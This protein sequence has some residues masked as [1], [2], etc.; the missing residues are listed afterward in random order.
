VRDVSV[1]TLADLDR[2]DPRPQRGRA[3][4]GERDYLCP[5]PA[6]AD[7]QRSRHRS[8]S[9]NVVS[10]RWTCH[11]CGAHGILSQFASEPATSRLSRTP[12]APLEQLHLLP[13]TS[14][15]P[16]YSYLAEQRGLAPE[17]AIAAGVNWCVRS[18]RPWLALP[19]RDRRGQ[20]VAHQLR[21]CDGERH[22]TVGPKGQGVF[23][24]APLG[25]VLA[26]IA[27]PVVE[28][29]LDALSVASAG[30]HA[31]ATCG[32]SCADWL[33]GVLVGHLVLLG[34]DRD[35]PDHDGHRAGD[36][37]AVALSEVLRHAGARPRRW[38]PPLKD[39]N[40]VLLDQGVA[41]IEQS[42]TP[43]LKGVPV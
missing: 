6:C 8:L 24:T 23:L 10:G 2:H 42:L 34:H 40:Q 1:L 26:Q 5:L 28:A 32:K 37:A 9:V 15:S 16:A 39:W 12:A 30:L 13:I 41:A 11:R 29:P 21:Q 38:R 43:L 7:K 25:Q 36:D 18:G 19:V 22:L 35:V 14:T 31:I 17:L 27:V 4:S 33:P 20:R 3:D